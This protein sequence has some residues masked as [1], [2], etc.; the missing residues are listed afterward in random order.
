M[1]HALSSSLNA[2]PYH[3]FLLIFLYW[4]VHKSNMACGGT[5]P[6]VI[7][8]GLLSGSMYAAFLVMQ[9]TTATYI[10]DLTSQQRPLPTTPVSFIKCHEWL[11]EVCFM[12][13]IWLRQTVM[14]QM[15]LHTPFSFF[16][17][18]CLPR[19]SPLTRDGRAVGTGAIHARGRGPPG[20]DRAAGGGGE[21]GALP[22]RPRHQRGAPPVGPSSCAGPARLKTRSEG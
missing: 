13:A 11:K 12:G 21:G 9:N 14:N 6:A 2:N 10:K 3:P 8:W 20:I 22:S 16:S 1:F 18:R 19:V 4:L 17:F 5:I 7:I 15:P